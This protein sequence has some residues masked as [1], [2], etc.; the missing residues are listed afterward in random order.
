M[1]NIIEG[2]QLSPQQKRLW[3]LQQNSLAYRAQ[4]GVLIEGNLKVGVLKEALQNLVSQHEILR[5]TFHRLAGMK[6]PIQVI[7]NPSSIQWQE[8]DISSFDIQKQKA[9]IEELFR[10][11]SQR[12]FNFQQGLLLRFT[13]LTLSTHRHILLVS[14]PSLCADNSTLN[15]LVQEI[16][17]FYARG[18][19]TELDEAVVQYVQFSAWQNELLAAEDGET[20]TDYWRKQDISHLLDLKLPFET[21]PTEILEFKPELITQTVQPCTF[22]K[23]E[24][25]VQEHGIS[26]SVFLLACWQILLKRLTLQSDIVVGSACDGR[27]SEELERAIGLFT[28]YLP[29][30]CHLEDNFSLS[31]ILR[32]VDESVHEANLGYEYFA[33]E[34]TFGSTENIN[35][36]LSSLF[37]FDFEQ[38]KAK[39]FA[40]NVSFSIYK[41]YA[42]VD[43][44]KVK[45]FC[46][47]KGDALLVEFHYDSNL[48]SLKDIERLAEQF[49]SLLGTIVSNP[50]AS[51]SEL[52]ILS[53]AERRQLL[54]EFNDTRQDYSLDKCIHH[55]IEEQVERTPNNVAVLFQEQQLT[56]QELNARANQLAHYLQALGVGFDTLVGICVERSLSMIV[57]ILGILKAGGA[58]VPINPAYP[59]ERLAYMLE[60]SHVPVLLTQ[61]PLVNSLPEH[62][63]EV[64]C[65]DADWD[66]IA[67]QSND[68]PVSGVIAEHLAYIIY[69]SGS[70][71]QPKGVQITHQNLVHS[72][73]ARILYYDQPVTN[74]L[75]TSPF[76]FDSSVA[77]I[78]WTLCQGG[79]LSLPH[80]NFQTNMLQFIQLITQHR[81]S[82]LLCV[83]SLYKLILD[84]IKPQ[85]LVNLQ[86]VTVA[87]ESCPKDLVER[88]RQ[89][90]P[91]ISL[92]NEY[93][94][95][96][97]TVWSSVYD[98]HSHAPNSSIPIG[99]PI[100]NTQI[101][102]LDAHLQ[103]VPIGVPGEVHIGGLGLARGYLNLPEL[104]A[105]KFIPNPFSNEPKARLYKTGD[106]ARYL[107]DGNLEFLGRIDDQVKIRGFR[108]ELGEI[109]TLLEQH[110]DLQETVVLAQEDANGDKR[111]VAYVV[112]NGKQ[113]PTNSE[114][115]R[116]LKD[117]LPEYMIPTAFVVLKA[118]PLTPNGKIDRQALLASNQTRPQI[119][120]EFVAPRTLSE[121]TLAEIWRQVFGLEQVGIHDNF[122]ELGGDSILSIQI[123]SRANERGL[124]F[125]LQQLTQYPTIHELG[126]FVKTVE[127]RSLTTHQ[128]FP[129][130]L[131][132]E[133]DQQRIPHDVEDAYPLTMLQAGMFFHS[134][135]TPDSTIYYDIVSFHLRVPYDIQALQESLQELVSRHLILRT[136]FDF[137]NFSEPLQLVHQIASIPLEVHD[138][139]HLSD[140]EQ[141]ER[142]DA[143]IEAEKSR[144]FDLKSAP[145]LRFQVHRRSEE[146][147]QLTYTCHHAILDG[148]SAV[149]MLTELFQHCLNKLGKKIRPIAPQPTATFRDYVA[150][151]RAALKSKSDRQYW[152]Q[153]LDDSTVTMLPQWLSSNQ[154]ADVEQHHLQRLAISLEL[155]EDLK[156]LAQSIG[157]PL[158]SVLLAAH[159]RVLN[160]L[161]GQSDIQTG[162]VSNVR[163]EELDG[164]R[165][166]GLFLN[167]LPFRL[168]LPGGTWIDLIQATFQTECELLPFR[169]Y[170]MA[171]LQRIKGGQPLFETAFNFVHFHVAQGVLELEGI[172]YL[173]NKSYNPTNLTLLVTFGLHPTSSQII[174]NLEYDSSKL[175]E[176]QIQRICEYYVKTLTAMVG[177]PSE[178]YE[179]H[180]LL[181]EQERYQLLV[182]WNE[183]QTNYPNA[184][185][186]HELFEA[187]VERTP[188]AVAVVFA[189]EFVTYHELNTKAN[190]LA[191]Y[192]QS[193]GVKPEVLVGL[194]VERSLSMVVALL[195]ILKAGGAYVP[196][197]PTYPAERL[198]YML[199]DSQIPVLLVES[200]FLEWLPAQNTAQVI[201]LD[202]EW[203]VIDTQI[204]EN[205]VSR[206]NPTNSA[207]VIYTSGSTGQP[208]GVIN[209]HQ[210]ICNRLLWM[211]D[212]YQLTSGDRVLQKTP[213]SFDVS[214]WE[215][216]WPMIAGACLVVA[217][218]GGH[219][220]TKYLVEL[221][222]Q[223]RITTVHFVPPMLQVLLE[224]HGLEN[225]HNLQ[226]VIC[227]GEALPLEVQERFFTHLSCNL[228][229]L[230]GPT[231]AAIDVTS[232][233]CQQNS[234]SEIVPIGRP[235]ANMQIYILDSNLQPAPIGTPG[236]LH[237][238]GIGLA[239][240][241]LN[242]PAFTSEKFIPNPFSNQ[243]GARLYKT[244]DLARYLTDGNIEFLGRIDNQVKVRGFRI[245]L[246]EIEAVLSQHPQLLQTVVIAREDLP[247]DKRLVAY[248]VP[249][250]E[251]APTA[252]DLRQFLKEKLPGYMVPS[253][254][255]TLS[256]LPLTPNGK[257]NR[258]AL[259]APHLAWSDQEE[260]FVAPRT[261]TEEVLAGIWA[262][263]LR[264][265]RV[266][267]YD[268]FFDLGG[269]SLTAAQLIFRVQDTFQLEV[270]LQTLFEA[271]TVAQMA[272]AIDIILQTESAPT[273][274]MTVKELTR[275]A[276]LDDTICLGNL[277]FEPIVEPANI[278]LTGTT[279]FL[280]AF[281]LH[282]LLVQTQADIYCLVR[283]SN[284]Q[285][286]KKKLQK[287]L[288]SYLLWD[289][290]LSSRIIPVVG[291]LSQPLFSL[292]EQEFQILAT[293]ADV[294]YHNGALV[295]FVYPYHKLKATNVLGTH[296]I[297]RL[298]SKIK[299]KP[300]HYIS[301][302]SVF[303]LRESV[304]IKIFREQDSL[305]RSG[306]LEGGYAQSK[307]VAEKLVTIARSRG[308]PICIYRPG[309]I[310][311]HSK[312]GL[313]NPNDFM[314]NMIKSCIQLGSVPDIAELVDMTP[315][316][317]VSKAVVHLSREKTLLGKAFHLVNPYPI[318]LKD[319]V[320]WVRSFGYPLRL[321]SYRKWRED[322]ISIARR[323]SD[324]TLHSLLPFFPNTEDEAQISILQEPSQPQI[325]QI[326]CQNTLEQLEG[327]SII[328]PSINSELLETYFSHFIHSGFLDAPALV[329]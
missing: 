66:M 129:F 193:L 95:T 251:P 318:D 61:Q 154:G 304:G 167:T 25:L 32:Q 26:T 209:T 147:L 293:K 256:N 244:G 140:V 285:E 110:P 197:D 172:E 126:Q 207:Y 217:Q 212:A 169:W 124:N 50:K 78:F 114:L 119:E 262:Q 100:A 67:Q 230:Y 254:F 274:T 19:Q 6:F 279:G 221:I 139:R 30:H 301:T 84:H 180:T 323:S 81:I 287:T 235:I 131:I 35:F 121:Q 141:E 63:A 75:L 292:S 54:V 243:S 135:Y 1:Q 261:A 77:G 303:P 152:T 239:R 72:T 73:L 327:T 69:T 68:N 106:L 270:P 65:L 168:Q 281:L 225:C 107:A 40:D 275:E 272:Q 296:E 249:H 195:G 55:L 277:P 300:V 198:S 253:A 153:K 266:S 286:G 255:V 2:F 288:E 13:I 201:C 96:E 170:P 315:V 234:N 302:V 165:I 85:Q 199:N 15:H 109:Q 305:E 289:E 98:C 38:Q 246:G 70:T 21:Q 280:G 224:Q 245:E 250:Q 10:E 88:H 97:G 308:L 48:Y 23:I 118:L 79:T 184:Q 171:E 191:H 57:G 237:I 47:D 196:F 174:V 320:N 76:A 185:C 16:S 177:E 9:W 27:S 143:L 163:P 125:S 45:L 175:C 149:S 160:L 276:I 112:P 137:T 228:H 257:V 238:A 326:D 142:L 236:E 179:M 166:L 22:R 159:V 133:Q 122:F 74:F 28:K 123:L 213:I 101:Y 328:C 92:F 283:A 44:F 240:C 233:Q 60:D 138:L 206:V 248:I 5:T 86:C 111:L 263:V 104:T 227:S 128:S 218:P 258:Q 83:P 117:K 271:S 33:W 232:W 226:H 11:E 36:I 231:E 229:N 146:T 89:L 39:F 299:V 37:C 176:E 4:L 319:L 162:L 189:D 130:S 64:I 264:R 136:S 108:V 273:T 223:Q 29:V 150:L 161:S 298:A 94:P 18:R 12:P 297:L 49:H 242:R 210:G 290:S 17:R 183:T 145:L 42:C 219:Q 241:Y 7:E 115:R 116:F 20:G 268:N 71:G 178:H 102:L 41:Q 312:T 90:L 208:K 105:E 93:G 211:Q 294:I 321:V 3:L 158:K 24:T 324:K 91:Q 56:Y 247:G 62:K 306:S 113:A 313:W 164:E 314:C 120:Q 103:L 284:A 307:W 134:E 216:F 265:E 87:G 309:R 220:D 260:T 132:C 173:G 80:E 182:E 144:K 53:N 187:Q 295:N 52:Q 214:V 155:S 99:R 127:A 46:I 31:Q 282:E 202:T 252:S 156:H 157:V 34:Q 267:V 186:I 58:Y 310:T 311:G 215:F 200:K 322:L 205:A 316:D 14:L 151:E 192:L 59:N 325:I 8:Y 329:N 51:I 194:C 278:F 190:Q 148:W 269:Y 203:A 43:R 82:H 259:P 317:Y 291:D 188:D 204:A 222:A 181:S